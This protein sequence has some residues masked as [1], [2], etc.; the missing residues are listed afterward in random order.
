MTYRSVKWLEAEPHGETRL[1][2]RRSTRRRVQKEFVNGWHVYGVR[3]AASARRATAA[4]SVVRDRAERAMAKADAS[5]AEDAADA[6][7]DVIVR[8]AAY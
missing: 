8:K 4:V 7:R 1:R 6:H 2:R 3:V 5:N